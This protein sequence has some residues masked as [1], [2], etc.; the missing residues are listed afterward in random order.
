MS[1]FSRYFATIM[2]TVLALWLLITGILIFVLGEPTDANLT[3][4][5]RIYLLALATGAFAC[6]CHFLEKRCVWSTD[7]RA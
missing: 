3:L 4:V 5:G 2:T 6:V 7:R 1:K